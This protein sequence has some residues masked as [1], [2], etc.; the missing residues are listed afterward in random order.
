MGKIRQRPAPWAELE[1]ENLVMTLPSDFIRNLERPDEV[2]ELW[3]AIMRS[4][5][6]LAATPAKF[7]RKERFVGD[8]QIS[9]GQ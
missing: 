1:F 8:V 4:V 2:A 5:S 3:D 6:D 9:A 7:P